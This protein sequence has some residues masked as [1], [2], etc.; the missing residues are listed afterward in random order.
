MSK[1]KLAIGLVGNPNC[2]KTTL[3]NALTGSRQ[4]VGNWP[5]VTVEKKIGFFQCHDTEVELVDLPGTYSLDYFAD[6]TS[7]DERVTQTYITSNSADVIINIVDASNLE[8]NL[9]LTTQLLETR[10]PLI[11]ALNMMDTAED[12]GMRI[13]VE[14]LSKQLGCPIIPIIASKKQGLDKLKAV[15]NSTSHFNA[16]TVQPQYPQALQAAINTLKQQFPSDYN[17]HNN[18]WLALKL[19]EG[20]ST[21]KQLVAPSYINIAKEL[22]DSLENEL[23]EELDIIAADARYSFIGQIIK[24][25]IT[26]T[27]RLSRSSSDKIDRIILNRV[28]GIPIFLIIMYLMFMLAINLG[29]AFIDFFD[30]LSGTIF[31]DGLGHL[32]TTINAPEWLKVILAD[33]MGGGIQTVATFIPVIAFLFLFLSI[34]E[35]SGYMARA[36][37]VMDRLMRFIGLPGKSFVPLIVGFGCNVPAVMATRTL[38]TERDRLMTMAM[39]PFMSCGARL[40]VY[41]LFAAAFFP[42]GGQNIVFLLYLLGITAAI[43]T[44]LVLK[45]TLLPG[46]STPFIMEL[47]PYHLPNIKGIGMSIWGRLKSFIFRAGAVIIPMVMVLNILNSI[48]TDGSFGH[49]DTQESVLASIGKTIAPA[50]SPMGITQ[51]NWPAAVGV[52]TGV[53]AKEAVVGTLNALYEETL[54]DTKAEAETEEEP[55]NFLGGISDAFKTIPDNIIGLTDK[56][57]DPLGISLANSEGDIEDV[58]DGV[59][60]AMKNLFPNTAAAFAY[61][62]LILLYFP[63]I[64]VIGAV[65]REANLRWAI[66]IAFWCTALGYCISVLFY[67][68]AMFSTHPAYALYWIVGILIFIGASLFSMKNYATTKLKKMTAVGNLS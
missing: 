46:E 28:L 8:R 9:Y 39:A 17:K 57:L 34:L 14:L 38:E 35:D 18:D 43:L 48:G 16:S 25:T 41:A 62:L 58:S 7:L 53:L 65:A 55:F 40:P 56:V 31:V 54:N 4:R 44:G 33:G 1:K 50:F 12:N 63:C 15:I 30:I 29:G 66:F 27:D 51:E 22:H 59:F 67:Q 52:F 3:F 26:R 24:Q 11:I 36:A 49:E 68:I 32:L 2:G 5:G 61:L 10:T 60:G 20:D 6:N 19:I 47:P 21:A 13:D 37:F 64:A 42:T 45:K 23:Q